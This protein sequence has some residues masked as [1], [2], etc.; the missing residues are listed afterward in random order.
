LQK[1]AKSAAKMIQKIPKRKLNSLRV[2]VEIV[3]HVKD[4]FGANQ[5]KGQ[6]SKNVERYI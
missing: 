2:G 6:K 5:V 4:G 1:Q 3:V